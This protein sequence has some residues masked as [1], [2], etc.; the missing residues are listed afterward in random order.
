ME[1]PVV[2]VKINGCF[3]RALVDNGCTTTIVHSTVVAERRSSSSSVIAFDGSVIQY[4]RRGGLEITVGEEITTVDAIVV[5]RIVKGVDIVLGLA[6][7]TQLG[8]VTIHKE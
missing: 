4:K 8:G 3:R 1:M 7:V 2:L 5:E 6:A